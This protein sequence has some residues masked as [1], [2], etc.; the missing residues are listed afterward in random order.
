MTVAA[1]E[2]EDRREH[3]NSSH[4]VVR[5][6]DGHDDEGVETSGGEMTHEM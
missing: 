3:R 5:M 6:A 4:R 2:Y 1:E